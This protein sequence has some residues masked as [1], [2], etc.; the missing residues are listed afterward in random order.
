MPDEN[1][2][3]IGPGRPFDGNA[4]DAVPVFKEPRIRGM[5]ENRVIDRRYAVF[6]G[7]TRFDQVCGYQAVGDIEAVQR[8]GSAAAGY[9]A[10]QDQ[11]RCKMTNDAHG[12]T[13]NSRPT[14]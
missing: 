2:N 6:S 4:E 1:R 14:R 9:H 8:S 13:S 5:H 3:R 11:C 7:S 12:F 10:G